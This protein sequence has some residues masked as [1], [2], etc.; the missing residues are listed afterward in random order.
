MWERSEKATN[1]PMRGSRAGVVDVH[2]SQCSVGTSGVSI[3]G[4]GIDGG[5]RTGTGF[6]AG[7]GG[8]FTSGGS[9]SGPG[10]LGGG[11]VGGE[12][13]GSGI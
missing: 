7:D 2:R 4:G 3:T 5:S 8:S 12:V 11:T 13:G 9:T 6:V 10:G 1:V